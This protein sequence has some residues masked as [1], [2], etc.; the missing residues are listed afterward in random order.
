VGR[1]LVFVV[2]DAQRSGAE[3]LLRDRAARQIS[4]GQARAWGAVSGSPGR[5]PYV[6]RGLAC[7]P[8]GDLAVSTRRGAVW[9]DHRVLTSS[10]QPIRRQALIVYLEAPPTEVFVTCRQ[11]G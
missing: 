10:T 4:I 1:G 11:A 3:R 9:T 6:V 7:G 2:D 5:D 8:G